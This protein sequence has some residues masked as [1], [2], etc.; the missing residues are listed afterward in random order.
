[1]QTWIKNN[2]RAEIFPLWFLFSSTAT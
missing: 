2:K 1:M